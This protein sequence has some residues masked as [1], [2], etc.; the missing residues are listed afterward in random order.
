MYQN[1]V[2]NLYI[3]K[4]GID[5]QVQGQINGIRIKG[6]ASL[7]PT[8]LVGEVFAPYNG[9]KSPDYYLSNGYWDN[10]NQKFIIN[11]ICTELYTLWITGIPLGVST[12]DFLLKD[13]VYNSIYQDSHR[14]YLFQI[15]KQQQA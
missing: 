14:T 15:T 2:K 10:N 1:S 5:I 13:N 4:S 3:G 12:D 9:P 7:D 11:P 6:S 8:T